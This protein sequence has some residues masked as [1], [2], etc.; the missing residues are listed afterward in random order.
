MII[1][2]GVTA[3]RCRINFYQIFLLRGFWW[4]WK[5]INKRQ[6]RKAWTNWFISTTFIGGILG[7]VAY[8]LIFAGFLAISQDKSELSIEPFL[9]GREVI[10]Y[11]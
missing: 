6:F 1:G 8:L 10:R 4:L 11:Y 3:A 2:H 7:G 9:H 5:N